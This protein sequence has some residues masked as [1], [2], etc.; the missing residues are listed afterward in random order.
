MLRGLLVSVAAAVVASSAAM[1]ATVKPAIVYDLGGKYDKS[2]NQGVFEGAKKFKKDTGVAFGE[3][4]PQ[5]AS[6]Y[7]QGLRTFAQ[8]GYDPILAVGFSQG[9]ALKK[10][11]TEFPKVHFGII[12][13]VVDQP[14]VASYVFK[15][16]EGS[17]LVGVLAAMA[18]KS[19]KVGF[20]G[21]MDIPLIRKFECGYA[22]GVK[23][24]NPKA[25]VLMN[26]TGTTADAWHDPVKGG[27]LTKA[28]MGQ[29][30]DVIYAAAGATG[31]GVL[32]AAADAKKL[33]IGVDSNQNYLHP[34]FVLTSMQK[35]VDVATDDLF[36]DVKNGKF[37]AGVRVLGLGENGVGWALDDNNKKLITGDMK[38]AVD[39]AAADIKSGKIQV[40]DYTSDQKC[41]Y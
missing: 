8:K 20:I 26:M 12:D 27:E 18:S 11:A 22:G 14:N 30:A 36:T 15:E 35:H 16:Q 19:G 31:T 23:S 37:Q 7:E 41:P 25:E 13:S 10:V 1:A 28:Q 3:F 24:V 29:G 2:F 40:H 33:G 32:Q 4:E 39:Q 5:N 38:K 21:G 6:Q 34:G 9:E 17:Y